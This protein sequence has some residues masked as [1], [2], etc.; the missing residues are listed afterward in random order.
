VVPDEHSAGIDHPH[1][2][3]IAFGQLDGKRQGVRMYATRL[4]R[5]CAAL[6]AALTFGYAQFVSFG[7]V[8]A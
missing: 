3:N 1:A 2:A 4:Y 7:H 6:W 8:L 5:R